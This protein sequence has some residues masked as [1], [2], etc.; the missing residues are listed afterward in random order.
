ME[1]KVV[2]E[3]FVRTARIVRMGVGGHE[4]ATT[5]E[6]PFWVKGK[7]WQLVSELRAGDLLSS[8]DGQW[9]SLEGVRDTGEED[10]VYNLRIADYHSYFVG[11]RDWGF[12]VWAHNATYAPV[13]QTLGRGPSSTVLGENLEAVSRAT[14]PANSAAHHI[15]AG[16]AN[17]AA[18]ARAILAREGIDINEAANGVF[19]PRNRSVAAPPALTHS[20][21]HTNVYYEEVTTRLREA[22]PGTVRDVLA[23]MAEELLNGTFPH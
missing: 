8:H 18:E 16:E 21:L 6:Y 23:Q 3:V 11:A 15:V 17:A 22:A 10:T 13:R 19:L 1:A 20:T 9:V 4:I 14:R 7:G 2:E 12:S 5:A